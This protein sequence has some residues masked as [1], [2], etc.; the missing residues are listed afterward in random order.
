MFESLSVLMLVGGGSFMFFLY[1]LS[2]AAERRAK[3]AA[4]AEGAP[5]PSPPSASR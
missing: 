5:A 2:L 4:D 3:E 1:R